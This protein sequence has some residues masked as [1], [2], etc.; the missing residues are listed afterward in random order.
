MAHDNHTKVAT[1][2]LRINEVMKQRVGA[3]AVS[4]KC[5]LATEE[6]GR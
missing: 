5:D 4:P 1:L 2:R 3:E 6:I